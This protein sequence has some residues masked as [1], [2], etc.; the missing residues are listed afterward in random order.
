MVRHGYAKLDNLK[1]ATVDFTVLEIAIGGIVFNVDGAMEQPEKKNPIS[2]KLVSSAG[3][4]EGSRSSYNVTSSQ[5]ATSANSGFI[6]ANKLT[7][8]SSRAVFEH[9]P[10]PSHYKAAKTNSCTDRSKRDCV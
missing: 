3:Q 2:K 10:Q 6:H 1:Y 5:P 7:N 4:R 8:P 9:E